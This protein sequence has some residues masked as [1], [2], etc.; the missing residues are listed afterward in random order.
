MQNENLLPVIV[1]LLG[2]CVSLIV[3]ISGLIGYIFQRHVK[4]NDRL[5]AENREAHTRIHKR[6]D[7]RIS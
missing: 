1:W 3:G 2:I 7:E 6:I 4:D 5:F